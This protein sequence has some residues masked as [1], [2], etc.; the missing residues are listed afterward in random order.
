[1][2]DYGWDSGA[3]GDWTDVMI[4]CA[5]RLS[6]T[7]TNELTACTSSSRPPDSYG[8]S[9]HNRSDVVLMT[10]YTYLLLSN[11]RDYFF[12]VFY[13]LGVETRPFPPSTVLSDRS[14]R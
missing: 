3:E 7:D 1:M 11:L 8:S 2:E 10:A 6:V 13:E 5:N 9:Q 14:S 12:D 4:R